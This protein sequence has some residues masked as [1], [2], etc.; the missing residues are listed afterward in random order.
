TMRLF[1]NAVRLFPALLLVCSMPAF[2][3]QDYG[4]FNAIAESSKEVGI[5]YFQLSRV[6][7]TLTAV[8][9]DREESELANC[10]IEFTERTAVSECDLPDGQRFRWGLDKAK[11]VATLEDL[12]TGESVTIRL[13]ITKD[14]PRSFRVEPGQEPPHSETEIVLEGDKTREE[15][16]RDWEIPSRLIGNLTGEVMRTLDI[17]LSSQ[18]DG[19]DA[20]PPPPGV[21]E[22]CDLTFNR[23]VCQTIFGVNGAGRL[24][25]ES[26]C[27]SI[28]SQHADIA[29]FIVTA[30]GCCANSFCQISCVGAVCN[31]DLTGYPFECVSCD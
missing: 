11:Q 24:E 14:V 15:F 7:E 3:Q 22:L 27:C 2:A 17:N 29:C 13:V 16:D 20:S 4:T 31:C 28:A 1:R 25:P 8:A 26:R 12:T 9:F 23:W 10:K 5:S 18:T 21:G 30:R 6:D 19:T